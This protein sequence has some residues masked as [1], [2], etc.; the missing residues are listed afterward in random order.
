MKR[1]QDAV[2]CKTWSW[3]SCLLTCVSCFPPPTKLS[4]C[5]LTGALLGSTAAVRE[6]VPC[7][8]I[9]VRE[10]QYSVEPLQHLS[11]SYTASVTALMFPFLALHQRNNTMYSRRFSVLVTNKLISQSG[12]STY[13]FL[14]D[15]N[16]TVF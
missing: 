5:Q 4:S 12:K 6:H 16:L 14:K 10:V 8:T 3:F 11:F 9:A 7:T 2:S 13:C 1:T 15:I